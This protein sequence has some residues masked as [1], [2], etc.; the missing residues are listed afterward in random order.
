M[1]DTCRAVSL[2][3]HKVW[4]VVTDLQKEE[5]RPARVVCMVVEKEFVLTPLR[6]Q[7]QRRL[8]LCEQLCLLQ[9]AELQK[10]VGAR[11]GQEEGSAEHACKRT[12]P[13]VASQSRNVCESVFLT[14]AV[15]FA[16]G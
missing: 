6:P 1:C 9:I 14:L 16:G 8:Q 7:R 12:T 15:L 3:S 4:L 5:W 2:K 11:G 10:E 13:K